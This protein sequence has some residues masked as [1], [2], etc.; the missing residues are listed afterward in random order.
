MLERYVV[1]FCSRLF[2]ISLQLSD[3]CVLFLKL[4]VLV[5]EDFSELLDLIHYCVWFLIASLIDLER[6]Q[7]LV[8]LL[9]EPLLELLDAFSELS[10]LLV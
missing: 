2:E 4:V 5:L 7:H 8:L 9:H 3:P 6:L 1:V 10:V